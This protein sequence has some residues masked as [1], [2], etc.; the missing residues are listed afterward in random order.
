MYLNTVRS[1]TTWITCFLRA[2]IFKPFFP[3]KA[4]FPVLWEPPD[5]QLPLTPEMSSDLLWCRPSPPSKN[6]LVKKCCLWPCSTNSKYST[7]SWTESKGAASVHLSSTSS[8]VQN[9]TS[10]MEEGG[11]ASRACQ[12]TWRVQKTCANV[13]WLICHLYYEK[14]T[15]LLVYFGV[16]SSVLWC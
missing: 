3:N 1:W 2:D 10:K 11:G 14:R 9:F 6:V 5:L 16:Y 15:A 7:F 12:L 13:D 4:H 8:M